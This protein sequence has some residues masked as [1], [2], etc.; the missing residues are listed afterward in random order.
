MTSER[1][2]L[3]GYFWFRWVLLTVVGYAVGCTVGF[4]LGLLWLGNAGIGIGV[5]T[6]TGFMQWLA[7]RRHL[8]RSGWW[9]LAG[10]V[11]FSVP[12]GLY[13][14][15][16][17]IWETFDP[18]WA[19]AFLLCGALTGVIQERVLRHRL[20]LSLWWVLFSAVGWALSTFGI[21]LSYSIPPVMS[22]L[23]KDVVELLYPPVVAGIILGT[24]SGGALIWLFRQADTA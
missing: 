21:E 20:G 11:G 5:G 9:V 2:V 24:I 12:F 10:V 4:F 22:D 15:I 13:T 6:M 16:L 7:L 8:Q 23:L 18:G 14:V 3:G 17:N 1:V 19:L